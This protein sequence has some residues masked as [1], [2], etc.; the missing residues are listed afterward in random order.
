MTGGTGDDSFRFV[1]KGA[2]TGTINGGD[3]LNTL[4][5]SLI[6]SGVRAN[7]FAGTGTRTGGVASIDNIIG[8]AGRDILVGDAGAN[9]L[10]GNGGRDILIGGAGADSLSGGI[11]E[12]ILVA[13][14]TDHDG[15]NAA[16]EN[17]M[18]E[19]KRPIAYTTRVRHLNR[20]LAGG[21]NGASELTV[22]TV[23]NDGGAIDSLTG[24]LGRDWF[25]TFA[26]DATDATGTETVTA[27]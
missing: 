17:L 25:I 1:R 7:L 14:S 21:L 19:W 18:T 3:G 4:D 24:G 6:A 13:G 10:T 22:A 9:R 12:D 26:G 23:H 27:L 2:V 8:G 16:L 5:Y 11:G 15:S 20:E